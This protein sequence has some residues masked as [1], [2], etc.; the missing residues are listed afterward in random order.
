MQK[1]NQEGYISPEIEVLAII[2]EQ[3]FNVSDG[4]PTITNPDMGWGE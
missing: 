3:G 4:D 1:T 2:V